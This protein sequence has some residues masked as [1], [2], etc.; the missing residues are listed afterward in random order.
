MSGIRSATTATATSGHEESTVV[1]TAATQ[2]GT[3]ATCRALAA[4]S[5]A[6]GTASMVLIRRG[7]RSRP[8]GGV[9]GVVAG[10]QA[11]FLLLSG[12]QEEDDDRAEQ[13][14]DDPGGVGPVR[15]VE[16]RCLGR[17][18]DRISVLGV[19]LG[20]RFCASEGLLQ[21]G[22]DARSDQSL[23]RRRGG[24]DRGSGGGRVAGRQQ[25]AKDR[26]HDRPTKVVL[27]VGGARRHPA[28]AT[29]TEPVS[30]CDAGVPAT[31]TPTPTQGP[32][33]VASS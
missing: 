14:R 24:G 20:N 27:Q 21:L 13:D 33:K 5:H 28:W 22:L 17:L 6:A 3:S 16:E 4:A 7:C 18:G 31:P 12:E 11:L 29:G 9:V 30:E 32:G 8:P 19:L 2:E 15:A 26:L 1:T 10:E 25:G 23:G